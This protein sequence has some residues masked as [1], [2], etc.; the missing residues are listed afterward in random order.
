MS[1]DWKKD[2]HQSFVNAVVKHGHPIDR[3][4]QIYWWQQHEPLRSQ[5]VAKMHEVG[6]D[7]ETSTYEESNWYE[8]KGTFYTGDTRE[9]GVDLKV[10]LLDGTWQEWRY[11]GTIS[12][13]IRAVLE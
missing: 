13:L 11:A 10:H 7:Y 12:E 3:N 9:F 2:F 5:T 6:I 8:F 4:G 1:E